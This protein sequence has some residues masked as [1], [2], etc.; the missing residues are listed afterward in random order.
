MYRFQYHVRDTES[1]PRWGWL[2]LACETT[3]G[4]VGVLHKVYKSA[5]KLCG[6]EGSEQDNQLLVWAQTDLGEGTREAGHRRVRQS[7]WDVGCYAACD[8]WCIG[9]LLRD[10][11]PH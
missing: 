5:Q 1:D 8:R 7:R 6:G 9:W 3:F 11:Q 4:Y 10:T 2:G